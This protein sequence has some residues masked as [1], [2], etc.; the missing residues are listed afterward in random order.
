MPRLVR[1]VRVAWQQDYLLRMIQDLNLFMSRIVKLRREAR[2]EEAL[3]LLTGESS[4]ISGIPPTLVYAL[5]NDD[6]IQTLTARGALEPER[7]FAIAELFREE[8]L[9]FLQMDQSNEASARFAK[10]A[11]L[12]AEA[13]RHATPEHDQITL[14]GLRETL[15]NLHATWLDETSV[16]LVLETLIE[17][18][19]IDVADNVVFELLEQDD[20]G[21]HID[22]ARHAYLSM[23]DQSNYTLSQAGMERSE[24]MESL[25]ALPNS[26]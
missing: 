4:R 26:A 11:R 23:L 16:D 5:S 21:V 22:R 14:D 15:Q 13:L 8:G 7:C 1:S 18:G 17:R 2:P 20:D 10:A 6:L 25:G 19:A 24:I 12:Y 9:T 3:E